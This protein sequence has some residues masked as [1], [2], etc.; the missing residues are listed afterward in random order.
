MLQVL[1]QLCGTTLAASDGHI[2]HVKDVYFDDDKWTARYLV[3][4]TGSWIPGRLVLISPHALGELVEHGKALSVNLTRK[5]IENS[6]T[7]E[8]HKPLSRQYEE[9]YF[10]YYG[11]PTYWQGSAVWGMSAFPGGLWEAG[12]M[13]MAPVPEPLPEEPSPEAAAKKAEDGHLR[14]VESI[15]GYSIEA[16]D[17]TIGHVR[18]F[19]MDVKSWEIR[20]MVVETGSWFSGKKVFIATS[21]VELI[22]FE[23]LQVAVLLTKAAIQNAP[24]DASI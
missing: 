11:W 12:A 24:A 9:E 15:A 22:N 4:D 7:I 2:G 17:G 21:E 14:S 10:K 8:S 18:D 5:Q 20:Q 23:E 13:P 19:M 1:K 3:V 16:T 6:P